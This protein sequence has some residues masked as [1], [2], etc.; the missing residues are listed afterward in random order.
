MILTWDC[1][2]G[3]ILPSLLKINKWSREI[4]GFACLFVLPLLFV[5]V[6]ISG[7]SYLCVCVCACAHTCARTERLTESRTQWCSLHRDIIH[8][9]VGFCRDTVVWGSPILRWE[10]PQ[11]CSLNQSFKNS[12]VDQ[13]G[14]G[15]NCSIYLSAVPCVG[16]IG[17]CSYLL[18]KR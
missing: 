6:V 3:R 16:W 9:G 12:L 15:W 18:W 2:Q 13:V 7:G 1:S 10:T 14:F 8:D 5:I 17:I 11:P 4:L